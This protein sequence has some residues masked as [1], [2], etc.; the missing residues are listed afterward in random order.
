M[1]VLKKEIYLTHYSYRDQKRGFIA[2]EFVLAALLFGSIGAITWA[3]R[4]TAGWGG[5]DGTIVPGLMW[6]ILWYYLAFRKGI[7][8]RGIILWLGLGIALGGELG[9]GQYTS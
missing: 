2:K 1:D 8:A 6:G 9:Y 7:D 4:G 5:V 3:I